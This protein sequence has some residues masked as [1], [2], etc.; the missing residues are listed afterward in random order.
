M[1]V[2]PNA[3]Q[4]GSV[5]PTGQALARL[6]RRGR[7]LL[8]MGSFLPYKNV[9]T[10]LRAAGRLPDHE[11]HLLSGISPARRAELEASVPDGARVVFHDGAAIDLGIPGAEPAAESQVLHGLLAA[12]RHLA[13]AMLLHS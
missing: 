11:L 4:P 13:R 8:Y 6:P 7:K 2:V 3:P 9:E 12:T 1:H 10:L 5:L